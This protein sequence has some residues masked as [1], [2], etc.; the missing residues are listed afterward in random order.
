MRLLSFELERLNAGSI[1]RRTAFV[2]F[3]LLAS[4]ITFATLSSIGL[5]PQ[6]GHVLLER[7]AA[8][9]ALGAALAVSRPG[10]LGQ[11]LLI[12]CLLAVGLEACQNLVPSRHARALDALEKVAGGIAGIM[13]VWAVSTTSLFRRMAASKAADPSALR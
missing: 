6:T 7:A 4:Y 1:I 9:F 13:A 12:I 2:G 3:V 10:R 5:R 8:Y 11:T